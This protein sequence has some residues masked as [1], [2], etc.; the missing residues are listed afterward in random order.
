MWS[1]SQ[2][3]VRQ[4]AASG[5]AAGAAHGAGGLMGCCFGLMGCLRFN[6]NLKHVGC[7]ARERSSRGSIGR[8]S[9]GGPWCWWF[10][11]VLLWF[12]GVHRAQQQG[13]TMVL[14]V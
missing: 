14:V 7:F 13:R 1:G 3:S 11:G 6:G 2:G 10:N 9:M 4:G 5:A 12:N 8:S